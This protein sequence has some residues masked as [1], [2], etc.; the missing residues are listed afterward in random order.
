MFA[1]LYALGIAVADVVKSRARLEAEILLL[2]HQLT[3]HCGTPRCGLDYAVVIAPSWFGCVGYGQ[4]CS[5][6]S[7]WFSRGLIAN[8][9]S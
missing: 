1:I 9:V 6:R 3:L 5:I 7:R 2:R 4:A 8:R